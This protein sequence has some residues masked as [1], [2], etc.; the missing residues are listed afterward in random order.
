MHLKMI[1]CH[2]ASGLSL[3]KKTLGMLEHVATTGYGCTDSS[4]ALLEIF[5]VQLNRLEVQAVGVSFPPFP[6]LVFPPIEI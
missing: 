5:E 1:R 2:F 4:Q 6:P 3:V